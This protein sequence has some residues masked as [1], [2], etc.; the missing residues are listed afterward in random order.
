MNYI[1][2]NAQ[3]LNDQVS[4]DHIGLYVNQYSLNLGT[5]GLRAVKEFLRRGRVAGFLPES[6]EILTAG[7]DN[8]L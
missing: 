6:T 4:T 5:G 3:E 8:S 2:Q 7:G 1:R